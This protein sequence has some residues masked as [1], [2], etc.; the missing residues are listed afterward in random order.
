V[1]SKRYAVAV[2]F[3]VWLWP[4]NGQAVERLPGATLTVRNPTSLG[5]CIDEQRLAG[6]VR[7][8][9]SPGGSVDSQ[10][11]ALQ[12]DVTIERNWSGLVADLRMMGRAA[13]LRQIEAAR[14]D[15][16]MDALAVTIAMILDQDAKEQHQANVVAATTNR[17]PS[18]P[19]EAGVEAHK[20]RRRT[21]SV[22]RTAQ[23]N[24]QPQGI[25]LG[26]NREIRAWVGGGYGSQSSWLLQTGMQLFIHDWG[27]ELGAFWQPRHEYG[28][29]TGNLQLTTFG[30]IAAGCR[31]FGTDWRLSLCVRGMVGA[32][33]VRVIGYHDASPSPLAVIHAGPSLGIE[34]GTRWVF[35]L[36]LL[37]QTALFNRDRFQ[38]MSSSAAGVVPVATYAPY[39]VTVWLV[40]R[41]ALSSR[42]SRSLAD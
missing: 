27:A 18:R 37:E 25:R 2:L 35:G 23:Y 7:E 22:E 34:T 13:G 15:G 20:E 21:Q 38:I 11:L 41:V 8:Q 14:C 29:G 26:P 28:I 10:A 3:S 12:L 9:L 17:D 40:A 32:E 31:R 39:P 16:L 33:R 4:H 24:Q 6:R 42:Q 30:G 19:P 5:D 36:E 1:D